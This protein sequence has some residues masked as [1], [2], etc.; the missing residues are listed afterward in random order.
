MTIDD[1]DIRGGEKNWQ[2]IKRGVPLRLEIGPKDIAKNAVFWAA[3]T[4]ARR[5]RS[6][7]RQFVAQLPAVL[8][9]IQQGLY[10]RALEMRDENT[11]QID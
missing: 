10:D 11:Q 9:E 8:D 7:A 6:I 2:H 5:R 3:A 4:R 1:R